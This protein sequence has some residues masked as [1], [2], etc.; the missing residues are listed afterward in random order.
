MAGPTC[1]GN[2]R[3]RNDPQISVVRR[4][5][6]SRARYCARNV[7]L[8]HECASIGRGYRRRRRHRRGR[9]RHAKVP[10]PA[11]G[12]SP[13]RPICRRSSPGSS[14][15]TIAAATCFP[16]CR[17][18]TTTCGCAATGS[19]I[20]RKSHRRPGKEPQPDGGDGARRRAPRPSTIRRATGSRCCRFPTR[21]SFPAPGPRQRHRAGHEEPGR[22][23]AAAR[24]PAAARRAISSAPRPRARFRQRWA[25]SVVDCRVGAA[26]PV[27]PGR[28]A[29]D[30]RAERSWAATA[31]WRCSR[32]G[33]IAS[34]PAKCRRRRRVRRASS[35]T[36]SSR[37]G[38]GPIRRRICTTR[39][40]PTGATR[41]VNAN[42]PIYGALELSADYL[43]VLDPVRHTVSAGPL[44][45]RDPDDAA[46]VAADAAAV[47]VLGRGGDLD[48]QEQRPQPDVRRA[49]AASGSR[50]PCGRPTTRSSARQGRSH[51]SAKLFPVQRCR[52]GI[53]PCTIRRRRS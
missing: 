37:C 39:S 22:V 41:R 49:R 19:S 12:S 26:H 10:R 1:R 38:T 27:R 44:T 47:A 53:S 29:D 52:A 45:V 32:T 15:P 14:S 9:D 16:I 23:A 2:E 43:P 28:R 50:P 25:H 11:S 36:S 51:P 34:R 3:G 21:A 6:N 4:V 40:R 20:R 33:P 30:Q 17:R 46:D 24:S 8:A 31:R 18:R 48:E 5:R 42:G 13:R 7:L 35:A